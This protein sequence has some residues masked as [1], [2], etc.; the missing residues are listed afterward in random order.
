MATF[1]PGL[2]LSRDFFNDVVASIIAEGYPDLRFSAALIGSG[3]EVLGYDTKMSADHHWGP[4]VMLFLSPEDHASHA[5]GLWSLLSHRLP[6]R[7]SG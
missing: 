5:S 1:I 2:A 4:R 3:S 7:F 6:Y